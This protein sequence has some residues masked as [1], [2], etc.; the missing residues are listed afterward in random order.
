MI[1]W[2]DITL[3]KIYGPYFFENTANVSVTINGDRCRTMFYDFVFPLRQA[4]N[5]NGVWFQQDG[6]TEIMRQCTFLRE[7][8]PNRV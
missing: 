8:C 4:D 7:Q 6:A 5:N 3:Q 2:Y 1:A